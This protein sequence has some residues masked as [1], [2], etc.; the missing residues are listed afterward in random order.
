MK[1]TVFALLLC[2]PFGGVAQKL[3]FPPVNSD[4]WET[5]L[6][7]SLR[8]SEAAID[9]LYDYLEQENTKV[10][11]LLKD[12]KIVLEKYFGAHAKDSLWYWASAGKSLAVFLI[13]IAQQEKYLSITDPVSKYL[14]TGWTSATPEQESKITIRNQLTMTSGLSEGSGIGPCTDDTCLIYKADAGA[15][16]AYHNA[17]YTLLDSVLQ[18]ASGKTFNEFVRLKL[19]NRTGITASYRRAGYNK[20][21]FSTARDMARYGLLVLGKGSWDGQP[22]LTDTVFF[23]QMVNT[24]QPLNK[25]YG[26]LWWLN[27]KASYMQPQSQTVFK[28]AL[29]P[30]A[31]ADV[32]AA[33]GVNGQIINVSPSRNMVV[34]RMGAASGTKERADASSS[35]SNRIWQFINN[36]DS[37]RKLN[38]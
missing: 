36:V 19:T 11:I 16:W 31:P 21:F 3:Y 24:S 14:G 26:Y 23:N 37:L 6:P 29:F 20:I 38:Y 10:F 17:P 15:R 2:I 12:G 8:W 34:V 7:Q 25:S 1:K 18:R 30:D 28:G 32:V 35:L 33:L 13:G 22:V 9:S 4:A 27:G 5:I